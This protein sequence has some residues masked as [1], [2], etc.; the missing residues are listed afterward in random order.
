MWASSDKTV[1]TV[2]ANGTVTAL[3]PGSAE[4]SVSAEFAEAV[5]ESTAE[6]MSVYTATVPVTVVQPLESAT[7][8]E[9]FEFDLLAGDET[10]QLEV[11]IQPA[12]A[13]N[14]T[15][16]YASNNEAVATLDANGKITPVAEGEAVIT[17]TVTGEDVDGPV[18]KTLTTTVTV[19]LL[20]QGIALEQTEGLLYVGYSTQLV[21]YTLPEEAP[22]STYTYAS[23][24]DAVATVDETGGVKAIGPGTATITV[25]SAEGHTAK[26]ALTVTR[27]PA[28]PSGS[29]GS[30]NGGGTAPPADGGGGGAPPAGGDG[31][32][33]GTQPA[34]GGEGGGGTQNEAPLG[35]VE[36]PAGGAIGTVNDDDLLDV[37]GLA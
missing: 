24:D 26:Y 32:G 18:E 21:P 20:P 14:T 23:S 30:G 15:V 2:D 37:D 25:T 11:T 1:A 31:G 12:D 29:G 9:S 19:L 35:T 13:S 5:P 6:D 36:N 17:T 8:Q 16:S 33:G 28:P 10:A 7:V 3:A 22:A 4:I 34:G 27:P